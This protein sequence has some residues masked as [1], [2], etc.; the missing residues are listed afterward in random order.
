MFMGKDEEFQLAED[1][2]VLDL[3][4]NDSHT[5]YNG[6]HED[7]HDWGYGCGECNACKLRAD[8]FRRYRGS[9]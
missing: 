4:I 9:K 3:V 8:G 6:N 1:L 2:G 5:C 7:F